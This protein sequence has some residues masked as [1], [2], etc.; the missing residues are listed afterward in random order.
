[1]MNTDAAG[2]PPVRRLAKFDHSV[3]DATKNNSNPA[4]SFVQGIVFSLELVLLSSIWRSAGNA[5]DISR[6]GAVASTKPG[7]AHVEIEAHQWR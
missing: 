4:H 2:E 7:D 1:M 5:S 3:Y 6:R